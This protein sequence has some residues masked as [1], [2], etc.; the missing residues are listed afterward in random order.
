MSYFIIDV[1][2][3]GP[4]LGT[5]S[6]VCFA[7]VKVDNKLNKHFVGRIKPISNTYDPDTLLI[8]GFTR[9]EHESFDDP[10]EVFKSFYEWI[11][12]NSVGKPV[13]ISDNNQ[14]DGS[15]INW[16]FLTYLGVNPFGYSSRRIGDL[17]CGMVKDPFAK[18]KQLRNTKADHNPL[19]DA[20]GNA[21]V[22]L[23]MID[24]GL[25]LKL[26]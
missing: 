8:S 13:L 26:Q 17:Y 4:L 19:N 7:A 1:E 24:M 2:S 3:D 15:W 21:E 22:I 14:Y 5:N 23:K 25:K 11:N 12:I 18:W 6:M 10:T 20:L 16:Y 9:Q